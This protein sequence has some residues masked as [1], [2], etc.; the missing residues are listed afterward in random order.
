MNYKLRIKEE[1][2][3][4]KEKKTDKKSEVGAWDEEKPELTSLRFV[5]FYFFFWLSTLDEQF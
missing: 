2:E 4:S 5:V 3:Q 1:S